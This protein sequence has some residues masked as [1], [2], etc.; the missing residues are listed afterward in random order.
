M[1]KLCLSRRLQIKIRRQGHW[2]SNNST[3]DFLA[4]GWEAFGSNLRTLQLKIP[5]EDLARVR[6]LFTA[7]ETKI[8]RGILTPFINTHLRCAGADAGSQVLQ[9]EAVLR[10]RTACQFHRLAPFLQRST[11]PT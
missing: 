11:A 4:P 7:D 6:A 1:G 5:L 8:F 2:H 9:A 3:T 10:S